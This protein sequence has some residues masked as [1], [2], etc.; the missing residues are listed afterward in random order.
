MDYENSDI[1]S[2]LA[3]LKS[4]RQGLSEEEAAKEAKRCIRCDLEKGTSDFLFGKP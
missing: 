2:V 3:E 1:D 4:S